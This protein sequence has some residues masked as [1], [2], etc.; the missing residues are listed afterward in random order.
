MWTLVGQVAHSQ[1]VIK[2]I[3]KQSRCLVVDWPRQ[4]GSFSC[5]G[6]DE[7]LS[8]P[9]FVLVWTH[10]NKRLSVGWGGV[11][12]WGGTRLFFILPLPGVY[13]MRW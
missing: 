5:Q 4:E 11:V 2:M 3:A 13:G 12:V 8:S 1:Q 7:L 9:P 10:K 6:G